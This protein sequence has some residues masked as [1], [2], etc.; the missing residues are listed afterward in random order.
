M[1]RQREKGMTQK[2]RMNA[3]TRCYDRIKKIQDR[4]GGKPLIEIKLI[5]LQKVSF[6]FI[7]TL[8]TSLK[9]LN[10]GILILL[11]SHYAKYAHILA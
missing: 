5:Y 9:L 11:L 4:T 7:C 1:I 3:S 2:T 6:K 8:T 10:Y